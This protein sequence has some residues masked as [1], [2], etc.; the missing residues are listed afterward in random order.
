MNPNSHNVDSTKPANNAKG[1]RVFLCHAS[2]DKEEVARPLAES[3][4]TFGFEVWYDEYELQMGD[5]LREKID[6]GLH[7][8]DYGVVILSRSF[9]RKRWPQN[10]LNALLSRE[11]SLMRKILLPVWHGVSRED[12]ARW[13]PLLADRIA[14][15]TFKGAKDV[16]MA[17]QRAI[18]WD[19]SR[20]NGERAEEP[21]N[22]QKPTAI[23]FGLIGRSYPK[24][25]QPESKTPVEATACEHANRA[26]RAASDSGFIYCTDCGAV[27]DYGLAWVSD[28]ADNEDSGI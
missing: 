4:K 11:V 5:S 17:I 9:F 14:H 26:H 24:T 18:Q 27:V 25:N 22:P 8:C 3:L 20:S 1:V 16:A 15:N 10:E 7:A 21:S 12:V 28:F 19:R 6:T 13:S 23:S 2:E